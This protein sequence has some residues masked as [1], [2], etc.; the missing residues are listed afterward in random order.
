MGTE[1]KGLEVANL[2][3]DTYTHYLAQVTNNR[4]LYN[5]MCAIWSTNDALTQVKTS[6]QHNKKVEQQLNV[7]RHQL[8]KSFNA[9]MDILTHSPI[10]SQIPN[11]WYELLPPLPSLITRTPIPVPAPSTQQD[12]GSDGDDNMDNDVMPILQPL[13][14]PSYHSTH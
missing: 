7:A 11:H 2:H 8:I 1:Y 14:P 9:T 3:P 6:L 12:L 5:A 13:T 4:P 10:G